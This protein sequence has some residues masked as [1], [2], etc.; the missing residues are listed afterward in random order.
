MMY[1][2]RYVG[3]YV[4]KYVMINMGI[5]YYVPI[6]IGKQG[7]C[8]QSPPPHLAPQ[9]PPQ[10]S[11]WCEPVWPNPF[12]SSHRRYSHH[13]S[14]VPLLTTSV[15]ISRN[16][17][18]RLDGKY[19]GLFQGVRGYVVTKT[20]PTLRVVVHPPFLLVLSC[21]R[22]CLIFRIRRPVNHYGA[23]DSIVVGVF[24]FVVRGYITMRSKH[25]MVCHNDHAYQKV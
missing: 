11:C 1:V 18:R 13:H 5:R 19:G 14:S 24:A 17:R 20:T 8:V 9:P 4:T 12:L 2:C 6:S 10:Y 21:P 3:T 23:V 15:L 7:Q 16:P 25:Q 22:N